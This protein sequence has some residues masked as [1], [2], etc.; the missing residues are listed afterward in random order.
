MPPKEL[1]R[2]TGIFGGYD[3]DLAK[4]ADGPERDVIEIAD[5]RSHEK[6]GPAGVRPEIGVRGRRLAMT[7]GH[8]LMGE[9]KSGGIV[10]FRNARR[11]Y[12]ALFNQVVSL[13]YCPKPQPRL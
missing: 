2:P 11:V 6:E 13:N 4:N 12:T 3:G 5:R 1:G 8:G 7:C 9:E 10:P